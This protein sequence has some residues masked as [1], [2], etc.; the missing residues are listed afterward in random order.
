[1]KHLSSLVVSVL[2]ISTFACGGDGSSSSGIADSTKLNAISQSEAESLCYEMVDLWPE[3]D[4]TCFGQTFKLGLTDADCGNGTEDPTA[5]DPTCT[6][7]VGDA[8]AC[9]RAF[10]ALTDAQ[11][12]SGTAP[13]ACAAIDACSED[14]SRESSTME[15]VVRAHAI[16]SRT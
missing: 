12:C 7:T 6:A 2:S 5:V 8:R 4:V 9:L 14:E 10:A 13:A 1:M 11:I 16:I 15:T 3:R